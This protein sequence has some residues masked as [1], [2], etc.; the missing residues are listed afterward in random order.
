MVRGTEELFSSSLRIAFVWG[1]TGPKDRNEARMAIRVLRLRLQISSPSSLAPG[2][3]WVRAARC[4]VRC[5]RPYGSNR[6]GDQ[7]RIKSMR[8]T[9]AAKRVR[10]LQFAFAWM[11]ARIQ[12]LYLVREW[13]C[14]FRGAHPKPRWLRKKRLR[15]R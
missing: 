6:R 10:S 8:L 12:K 5:H 2:Q 4:K 1:E 11:R 15:L 7:T 14:Y 9:E 3:I 13:R